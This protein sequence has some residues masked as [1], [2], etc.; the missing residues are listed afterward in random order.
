MPRSG[1]GFDRSLRLVDGK[2]FSAVFEHKRR[3]HGARFN[4]H[5]A[6]NQLGHAR[7]GLAVSRRVS[8]KAVQRNR[9]KRIIRES[10]RHHRHLLGA[11]D[12]VVI[13]KAVAGSTKAAA[14]SAKAVAGSA[15]VDAGSAKANAG[16]AKAN[17]GSAKAN[18]GS[19]KANAGSAK[20]VAGPGGSLRAELDASWPRAR[21][22]C[23]PQDT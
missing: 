8:K 10:F 3:L 18:A 13:A 5:V 19:A 11:V 2:Q 6:P 17:A 4:I 23:R 16:S 21:Q 7:I 12:Y 15:K 9:I 20:A 1:A 14:G 22:K